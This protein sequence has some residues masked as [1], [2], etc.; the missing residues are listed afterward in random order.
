MVI[1]NEVMIMSIFKDGLMGLAVGEAFAV[2]LDNEDMNLKSPVTEMCSYRAYDVEGGAYSD[3]TVSILAIMDSFS[4]KRIFDMNDV[5][6]RLC[7]WIN[8]NTY[9]SVGTLFDISKTLRLSLMDYWNTHDASINGR[10]ED[11]KQDASVLTRIYPLAIYAYNKKMNDDTLLTLVKDFSLI[12]HNNE[13]SF[14]GAFIYLK[15]IL[16]LFNGSDKKGALTSL[17]R[18][19]YKK[20]FS[21]V[22]INKFDRILKDDIKDLKIKDIKDDDGVVSILESTLWVILN[23]SNFK[24]AL[25]SSSAIGGANGVRGSATGLLAGIING[26]KSIPKNWINDLKRKDYIERILRIYLS[27]I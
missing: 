6:D 15:Y 16:Y 10:M 27:V 5:C 2:Q 4:H 11:G 21:D 17:K 9:S 7:D 3:D 1:E 26:K 22:T 19:N 20:Y 12:S 8:E 13:I 18:Y 25:V 14:M 23:T 24:D